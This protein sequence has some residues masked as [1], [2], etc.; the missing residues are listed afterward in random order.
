MANTHKLIAT[1][2]V[3]TTT[4]AIVTAFT[5]IPQ[6]YNDL[7]IYTTLKVSTT[8]AWYDSFV[9][10]NNDNTGSGYYLY[11]TG[12]GVGSGTESVLNLR[13]TASNPDQVDIY[14][15]VDLYIPDY[16]VNGKYKTMQADQVA[17]GNRAGAIQMFTNMY[18]T[19]V[20]API[21]SI[22]FRNV[23]FGSGETIIAGSKFW[24]YGINRS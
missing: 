8:G 14:S 11:G 15:N 22:G 16:T 2:T 18:S 3:P 6:T 21:T 9:Y 5:S 4:S 19:T 12:T 7:R 20:T 17:E 10:F 23:A 13:V 24:L 1:Y